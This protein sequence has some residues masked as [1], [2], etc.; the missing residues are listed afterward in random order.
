MRVIESFS[1]I[2]N[3]YDYYETSNYYDLS[4]L[5]DYSSVFRRPKIFL[6]YGTAMQ[7]MPLFY[8]NISHNSLQ[9]HPSE[10]QTYTTNNHLFITDD[11]AIEEK[12]FFEVC[13]LL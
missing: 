1:D 9:L 6:E 13:K 10:S 11:L 5:F 3:Y 8:R 2:G 4:E 7:E 12:D